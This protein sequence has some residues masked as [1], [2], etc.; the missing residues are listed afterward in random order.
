M[1]ND[2]R[3][4]VRKLDDVGKV[5]D[6]VMSA[7][8]NQVLG[9]AFG[10]SDPTAALDKARRQAVSDARHRAE[11]MANE[12]GVRVGRVVSIQEQTLNRPQPRFESRAALTADAAVPVASGREEFRITVQVVFAITDEPTNRGGQ[13]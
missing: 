10:V 6:G 4:H 8:S 11:V 13:P 2:V 7:G 9:I 1:T 5:L 12:L 3:A